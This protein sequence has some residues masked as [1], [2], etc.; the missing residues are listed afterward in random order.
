MNIL[1]HKNFW[2]VIKLSEEAEYILD[3]RKLKKKLI[4]WRIIAV[5][6][7]VIGLFSLA[8]FDKKFAAN[9]GIADQIARIEVSGIITDNKA[10]ADILKKIAQDKSVKALIVSFNSPGGT[11]TGGE[12]LYEDIR[13]VAKDRPVVAVFGTMATSA[14]YMSGVAADHIIARSNSITGS[15]GVIMQWAEVSNMMDKLGVKMNEMKSGNLKAVPSPFQPLDEFG[16]SSTQDMITESHKWFVDLVVKRRKIQPNQIP[17]FMEGSIY[18]GRQALK[19]GL[20]DEIGSEEE[21]LNWLKKA[22]KVPGYL[23]VIDWTTETHQSGGLVGRAGLYIAGLIGLDLKPILK[24]L[25]QN[26]LMS[27]RHSGSLISKWHP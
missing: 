24:N 5:V 3:R 19:Y 4:L 16:R 9:L 23:P 12:A 26:G 1:F 14:A 22:K 20:I 10:R 2:K 17:G 7:G 15:V 25:S 21:A 27:A 11:T 18:S 6:I 8:T 13:R